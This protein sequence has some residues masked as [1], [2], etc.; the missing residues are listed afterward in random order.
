MF[1][2]L[3]NTKYFATCVR[4][5]KQEKFLELEQEDMIVAQYEAKFKLA[6]YFPDLVDDEFQKAK[7][8]EWGLRT[9]I[10]VRL[11]ALMLDTYS[12]VV[13]RVMLVEQDVDDF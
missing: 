7:K 10:R 13:N 11:T 2:E 9:N 3:F 6:R 5:Q 4:T 1:L 8:F 12:S